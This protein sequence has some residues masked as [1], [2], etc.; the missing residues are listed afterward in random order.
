MMHKSGF[1]N[2]IG[3]PNIGKS[4]L[5]NTL[6]G[7]RMAIIS[8]K[9]QTTRHRIMGILN[10]EDFQIVFSDTPGL[11]Q[12]PAYKMQEIMNQSITS[13]FEDADLILLMTE[14]HDTFPKDHH[15][16]V[17]LNRTKTPVF[18]I[19]NKIDLFDDGTILNTISTWQPVLEFDE[20]VPISALKGKNTERLLELILSAMPEGPEYYP[21]DR[22]SDRPERFFAAEIIREQVYFQYREEIPYSVQ[23]EVESFKE[24]DNILRIEADIYVAKQSQ[25]SIIIGKD[26]LSIKKLGIYS[27]KNLEN[28][29]RKKIYLHLYVRV[30]KNWRNNEQALRRFGYR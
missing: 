6:V 1:V 2:I 8:P 4:T 26:G 11:I 15:W 12:D 5:L 18:L 7:E 28:F 24:D 29:F 25:K 30:K 19:I 10:G 16:L 27:R 14:P 17:H 23:I 9:P 22:L 20:C 13:S 21:K 3:H